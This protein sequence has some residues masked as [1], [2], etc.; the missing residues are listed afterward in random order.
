MERGIVGGWLR[1]RIQRGRWVRQWYLLDYMGIY[2][3][4]TPPKASAASSRSKK[5]V[6]LVGA[7]T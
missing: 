1:K 2:Y 7:R 4:R 3:S 5:F 6:K